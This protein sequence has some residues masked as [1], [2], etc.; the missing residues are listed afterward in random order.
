[1]PGMK[2]CLL[3]FDLLFVSVFLALNLPVKF[4][5]LL[6]A[7]S[8]VIRYKVLIITGYNGFLQD[9]ILKTEKQIG[10]KATPWRVD[11]D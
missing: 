4:N 5:F 1:V 3:C 8:L 7:C 2:N 11:N 9:H 6:I 10:G